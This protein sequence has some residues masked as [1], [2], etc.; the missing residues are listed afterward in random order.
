M[1]CTQK[2]HGAPGSYKSY[3][4]SALGRFL[5]SYVHIPIAEL[6]EELPAPGQM[7]ELILN[8]TDDLLTISVDGEQFSSRRSTPKPSDVREIEDE[9]P[10]DA[11]EEI[12]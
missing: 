9:M 4:K 10:E 5:K 12:G 7:P 6:L 11:D 1:L 3:L 2:Y 8:M